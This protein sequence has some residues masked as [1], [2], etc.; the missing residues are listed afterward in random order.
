MDQAGEMMAPWMEF[1]LVLVVAGVASRWL[2]QVWRWGGLRKR[3]KP[4]RRQA[5]EFKTYRRQIDRP[6]R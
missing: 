6:R 3:R 2:Y 4:F 1:V 5:T